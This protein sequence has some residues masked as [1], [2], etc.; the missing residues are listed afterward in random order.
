MLHFYITLCGNV[1]NPESHLVLVKHHFNYFLII[2][3]ASIVSI[4][5]NLHPNL[6]FWLKKMVFGKIQRFLA[7]QLDHPPAAMYIQNTEG[8]RCSVYQTPLVCSRNP[9]CGHLCDSSLATSAPVC[10]K[11]PKLTVWIKWEE[12]AIPKRTK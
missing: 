11:L 12:A 7:L 1:A 4:D 10:H 8:K 5:T 3:A 2:P 9:L 6:S